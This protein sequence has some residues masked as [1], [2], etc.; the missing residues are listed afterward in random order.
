M[1]I[2]SSFFLVTKINHFHVPVFLLVL[3]MFFMF[4][5]FSGITWA[6]SC[7]S[8]RRGFSPAPLGAIRH[9]EYHPSWAPKWKLILHWHLSTT[10]RHPLPNRK[11]GT[12]TNISQIILP[13]R[14][15][16]EMLN[17]I[18]N[19]DFAHTPHH[20]WCFA[21]WNWNGFWVWADF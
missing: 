12:L 4:I 3:A 14:P 16:T 13:S 15:Q 1:E 17:V 21:P 5:N 2:F 18:K 9:Q 10:T 20:W 7:W 8:R 19:I 11:R 6:R